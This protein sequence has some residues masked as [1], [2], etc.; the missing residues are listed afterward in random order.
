MDIQTISLLCSVVLCVI[1]VCTFC[2]GIA[3][4][5]RQS[6]TMVA[7]LDFLIQSTEELKKS[8][9]KLQ[10]SVSEQQLALTELRVR[11]DNFHHGTTT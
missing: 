9:A 8:N 7:K 5:A 10:V 6:G 1:G 4:R 2:V 3:S 11:V